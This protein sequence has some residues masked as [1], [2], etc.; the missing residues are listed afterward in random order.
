MSAQPV[1][2][3][4]QRDRLQVE[5]FGEFGL[6]EPLEPVEAGQNHPLRPG[7][8]EL[9]RFVIGIGSQHPRYIIENKGEFSI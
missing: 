4:G 2:Q 3:P 9:A 8:A 5:H 7:D 6:L 1:E